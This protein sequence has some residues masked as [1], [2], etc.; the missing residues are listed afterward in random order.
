[1]RG[2]AALMFAGAGIYAIY[3]RACTSI[4]KLLVCIV[5]YVFRLYF[6][7]QMIRHHHHQLHHENRFHRHATQV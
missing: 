5:L 6:M 3:I 1:M 4:F 7:F 2:I